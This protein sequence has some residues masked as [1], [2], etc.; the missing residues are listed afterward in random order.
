MNPSRA[1]RRACLAIVLLLLCALAWLG[2]SGGVHQLPR[3]HTI[4]Q[5]L[6]SAAQ[7]AY[8][9][10]SLFAMITTFWQRRWPLAMQAGWALSLTL[11]GGLAPVVWGGT[12]MTAGLLS[13][14]ASLLLA[15]GVTWLWRVGARGLTSA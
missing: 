4:G 9:L 15:G 13:A 11:A 10:L 7:V 14:A 1:I 3:S 12:G 2:L 8:G 6:Q 5:G